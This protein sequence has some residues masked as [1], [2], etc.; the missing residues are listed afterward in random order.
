[1]MGGC[2]ERIELI[3]CSMLLP[4][5]G[6]ACSVDGRTRDGKYMPT[7]SWNKRLVLPEKR[8]QSAFLVS[9]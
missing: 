9:L 8:E 5:A 4:I 7:S 2:C 6:A 1:M 3:V